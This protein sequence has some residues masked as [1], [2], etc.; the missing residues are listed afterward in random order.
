MVHT[1]VLL[2][3]IC[4]RSPETVPI[5]WNFNSLKNSEPTSLYEES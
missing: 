3:T 5:G 1:V 4:R 2:E